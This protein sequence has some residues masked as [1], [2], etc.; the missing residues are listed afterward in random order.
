M[1]DKYWLWNSFYRHASDE[2]MNILSACLV[3]GVLY[4]R[5]FLFSMTHVMF[6]SHLTMSFWVVRFNVSVNIL[7]AEIVQELII[8]L[9]FC[10]PRRRLMKR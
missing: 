4:Y 7:I 8:I 6:A 1:T 5:R 10:F 9:D 3:R 2:N